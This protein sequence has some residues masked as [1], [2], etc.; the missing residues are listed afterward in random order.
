MTKIVSDQ[1]FMLFS[2]IYLRR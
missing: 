2:L 1:A